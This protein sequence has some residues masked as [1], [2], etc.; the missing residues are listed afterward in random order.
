MTPLFFVIIALFNLGDQIWSVSPAVQTT[1]FLSHA[2]SPRLT[3]LGRRIGRIPSLYRLDPILFSQQRPAFFLSARPARFAGPPR[4]RWLT[5]ALGLLK[6]G[7]PEEATELALMTVAFTNRLTPAEV[8]AASMCLKD[9]TDI[10]ARTAAEVLSSESFEKKGV[11]LSRIHESM[12]RIFLTRRQEQLAALKD[13]R[14]LLS[15]H[16][17]GYGSD[18]ISERTAMLVTRVLRRRPLP[19]NPK[20]R[21]RTLVA[22]FESR[23]IQKMEFVRPGQWLL[24]VT[25][26]GGWVVV[27]RRPLPTGIQTST[28]FSWTLSPDGTRVSEGGELRVLNEADFLEGSIARLPSDEEL[29]NLMRAAGAS[30]LPAALGGLARSIFGLPANIFRIELSEYG[31]HARFPEFNREDESAIYLGTTDRTFL[32]TLGS[33]EPYGHLNMSGRLNT[34][35]AWFSFQRPDGTGYFHEDLYA[36]QRATSYKVSAEPSQDLIIS[37]PPALLAALTESQA[38]LSGR[39]LGVGWRIVESNPSVRNTFE[40]LR[41]S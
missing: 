5:A 15:T 9:S 27:A 22:A 39:L 30:K 26:T 14:S 2:L 16:R 8:R 3:L 24:N 10:T 19:A 18:P 31:V 37:I 11:D 35:N 36:P 34:G 13:L 40:V 25:E 33:E 23:T 21:P 12:S 7:H 28:V 1:S 6:S 17:D 4:H 20:L 29:E 41:A 32:F 38:P